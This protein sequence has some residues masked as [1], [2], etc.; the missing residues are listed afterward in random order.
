[1]KYEICKLAGSFLFSVLV[2]DHVDQDCTSRTE[3]EA[4]AKFK[5]WYPGKEL[6]GFDHPKHYSNQPS[7]S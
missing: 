3:E 5:Q 7:R 4:R 2:D 1:M 6:L